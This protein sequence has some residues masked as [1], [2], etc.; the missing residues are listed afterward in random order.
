MYGGPAFKGAVVSLRSSLRVNKPLRWCSMSSVCEPDELCFKSCKAVL[1]HPSTETCLQFPV[2]FPFT[3]SHGVEVFPFAQ[4]WFRETNMFNVFLLLC[5][6]ALVRWWR[7]GMFSIW[8]PWR[9]RSPIPKSR[10]GPSM[11]QDTMFTTGIIITPHTQLGV[12][13]LYVCW[14]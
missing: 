2:K 13:Q 9:R 3:E 8:S 6:L 12:I 11:Q 5:L 14:H 7:G 10:A 1:Q 4:F